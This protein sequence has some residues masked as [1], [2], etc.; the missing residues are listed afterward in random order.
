MHV[1]DHIR[2]EIIRIVKESLEDSGF[3][4]EKTKEIAISKFKLRYEKDSIV[5]ENSLVWREHIDYWSC[6]L[7]SEHE[8]ASRFKQKLGKNKKY[9]KK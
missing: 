2:K 9:S 8:K 7:C 5:D 6:R 3:S 4:I 1:Q